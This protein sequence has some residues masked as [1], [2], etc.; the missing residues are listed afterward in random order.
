M[1][2][3]DFDSVLRNLESSLDAINR[4]YGIEDYDACMDCAYYDSAHRNMWGEYTNYCNKKQQKV[5][6]SNEACSQFRKK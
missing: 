2:Y 4:E 6:G 1:Y 3:N 5:K